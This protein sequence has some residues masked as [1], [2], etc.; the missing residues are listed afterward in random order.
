MPSRPT[1]R[2]PLTPHAAPRHRHLIMTALTVL[3]AATG[4]MI[5]AIP[6]QAGLTP[7]TCTSRVSGDGNYKLHFCVRG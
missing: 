5:T 7:R 2:A 6:A 3:L 4:S 1:S